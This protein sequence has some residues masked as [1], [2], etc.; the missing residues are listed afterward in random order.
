MFRG[1]LIC[2]GFSRV[3]LSRLWSHHRPYVAVFTAAA[4]I[5]AFVLCP[6]LNRVLRVQR[7]DQQTTS[8]RSYQRSVDVPP[9]PH[10]L[11]PDTQV[12]LVVVPL[13]VV[14]TLRFAR[15]ADD[16]LP[17]GIPLV[18]STSP[19]APPAVI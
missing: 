16:V 1:V 8:S 3:S 4:T 14:S 7:I 11:S 12:V 5:I 17:P 6:A 13:C 15:A 18:S 2:H 9:K 19:R 10:V